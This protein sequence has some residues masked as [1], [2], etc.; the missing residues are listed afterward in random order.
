MLWRI[1]IYADPLYRRR[2]R[3]LTRV[4]TTIVIKRI[5]KTKAKIQTSTR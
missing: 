2:L 1:W 4:K 5:M 3:K